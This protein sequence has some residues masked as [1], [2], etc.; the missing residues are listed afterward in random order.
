MFDLLPT[1][2]NI[3]SP[4]Y[5]ATPTSLATDFINLYSIEFLRQNETHFYIYNS[6][7]FTWNIYDKKS[8]RK[9]AEN[10]LRVFI[11]D[12]FLPILK[13]KNLELIEETMPPSKTRTTVRK[14]INNFTRFS[15]LGADIARIVTLSDTIP[16][17]QT[18]DFFPAPNSLNIFN[19]NTEKAEVLTI[20]IQ[21]T[22]AIQKRQ[23]DSQDYVLRES[24]IEIDYDPHTP[25]SHPHRTQ[26]EI[27]NLFIPNLQKQ[28]FILSH[29]FGMALHGR[30]SRYKQP[31]M[32][33]FTGI[34]ANGKSTLLTLF[35]KIFSPI[36]SHHINQDLIVSRKNQHVKN[37]TVGAYQLRHGTRIAIPASD[38]GSSKQYIWNADILKN[39]ITMNPITGGDKYKNSVSFEPEATIMFTCNELPQLEGNDI[40]LTNRLEIVNM[41]EIFQGTPNPSIADELI[42]EERSQ[43]F[44]FFLLQML[45]FQ[46][47]F[48]KKGYYDT[49]LLLADKQEYK[50]EQVYCDPRIKALFEFYIKPAPTS[51]NSFVSATDFADTLNNLFP[52]DQLETISMTHNDQFKLKRVNARRI[53]SYISQFV[54]HETRKHTSKSGSSNTKKLYPVFKR[55]T[56]ETLQLLYSFFYPGTD[57][58]TPTDTY[59]ATTTDTNMLFD[60]IFSSYQ[61]S[62]EKAKS[63]EEGVLYPQNMQEYDKSEVDTDYPIAIRQLLFSDFKKR[64]INQYPFLPSEEIEAYIPDIFQHTN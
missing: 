42:S 60:D 14:K 21:A 7:T 18:S 31:K 2:Y 62:F 22:P 30:K 27:F 52:P 38:I 8:S 13:E 43:I 3:Q 57:F 46:E 5:E 32:F 50:K 15:P 63:I 20:N 10:S 49:S 12:T 48:N 34:G 19:P 29:V 64:F 44:H 23:A 40:A 39:A 37:E 17:I 61:T 51:A 47:S 9:V 41:N 16:T 25:P 54:S 1:S 58:P 28:E 45:K 4:L 11:T 6:D 33:A 36:A 59:E 24:C 56:E 55:D 26:K 35:A 53:S